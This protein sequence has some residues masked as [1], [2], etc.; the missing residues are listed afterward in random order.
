MEVNNYSAEVT[1]KMVKDKFHR[2]FIGGMWD[3]LG[4]LQVDFLIDHGLR[5]EMRFLDVG[6]GC[7]RAGIHLVR[8]LETGNYYGLDMN[9]SLLRA[10]YDVEL[11]KAGIQAKLPESNLLHEKHFRA[12]RLGVEF[13][14]AIAQ[15]VFSHLPLNHIR[16]CLLELAKCM[17][18]GGVFFATYFNVPDGYQIE[19]SVTHSPGGV[20]TFADQ[21]PYHYTIDDCRWLINDLPWELTDIG[22]W[23][24]PR[25][26]SML[27]FTRRAS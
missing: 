12:S 2:D 24:H 8:Y 11:P 9:N 14:M 5:P 7:L 22:E 13:D 6:C 10:G 25:G 21:D 4:K 23:G 20:E 15:S 27:A 16:L 3:E 17:A 26:Q 19:H 18:P 1:R